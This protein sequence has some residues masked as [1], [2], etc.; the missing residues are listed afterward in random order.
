MKTLDTPMYSAPTAGR[1]VGLT[2]NRVRRW[3]LG[4][5]YPAGPEAERRIVHKGPVISRDEAAESSYASF[6]D[7]VDLLFVKEFL[8]RGISL[9]KLRKALREAEQILGEHHY[10]QRDFFTDG[11]RIYLQ[12]RKASRRADALLEL[13]SGGQWVIAPI[14][15]QLAHQ[16]QFHELTGFA[17]RWFPLGLRGLIVVD[18]EISFRMPSL[19]GRGIATANIYDLFL[20][21]GKT[22]DHVCSWMNLHEREVQAAVNFERHL[23]RA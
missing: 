17:Q 5:E 23:A 16:I 1:L 10:A 18:P 12:V 15:K 21:E 2:T 13:L 20:G 3:L 7:L 8:D 14:I 19:V 11:N 6:L 4:Y 22:L 9:Q